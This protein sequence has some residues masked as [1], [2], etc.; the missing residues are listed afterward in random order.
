MAH[1]PNRPM[2]DMFGLSPEMVNSFSTSN[3]GRSIL[4]HLQTNPQRPLTPY[5]TIYMGTAQSMAMCFFNPLQRLQTCCRVCD[6]VRLLQ[7]LWENTEQKD[8]FDFYERCFIMACKHNHIAMARWFL[9]RIRCEQPTYERHNQLMLVYENAFWYACL[10]NH[11]SIVQWMITQF[12][13]QK[14]V[15]YYLILNMC[16]KNTNNLVTLKWL[17][18]HCPYPLSIQRYNSLFQMACENGCYGMIRWFMSLDEKIRPHPNAQNNY[19][20]QLAC[21]NGH[22][23][24]AQYLWNQFIVPSGETINFTP[25]MDDLCSYGYL[26][27]LQWI[28]TIQPFHPPNLR[29]HH[30]LPFRS[31]CQAG[32]LHVARWLIAMDPTINHRCWDDQPFLHACINDHLHVA[33]WLWDLVPEDRPNHHVGDGFILKRACEREHI[34]VVR[35]LMT[36]Q[37]PFDP[38]I[39]RTH[40]LPFI[41][42]IDQEKK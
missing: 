34:R 13:C 3:Y 42:K 22:F 18:D 17:L 1:H 24:L 27:I 38:E 26:H 37:P 28:N 21:R 32:N 35:W 36:L 10:N 39:I 12:P 8:D 9:K 19:A 31:A 6:D 25:M 15:D 41:A 23:Q 5:E 11:L 2:L 20:F 33:Q 16:L 7:F 4:L 30:D 14:F 29:A 40:Y